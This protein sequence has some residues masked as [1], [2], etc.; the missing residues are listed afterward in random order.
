MLRPKGVPFFRFQVY[1]RVGNF[2]IK[3]WE[4]LYFLSIKKRSLIELFRQDV[5]YGYITLIFQTL[6]ENQMTRRLH[7]LAIYLY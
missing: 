1:Q 4:L 5:P 3:G 2:D 6:H 7:V